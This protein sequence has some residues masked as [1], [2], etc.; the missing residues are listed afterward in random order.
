M[1]D[2]GGLGAADSSMMDAPDPGVSDSLL[3]ESFSLVFSQDD[4]APAPAS[5]KKPAG[6]KRKSDQESA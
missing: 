4:P 2:S 1:P 6:R 3:G 5:G